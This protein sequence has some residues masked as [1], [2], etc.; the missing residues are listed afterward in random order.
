MS[1]S[2]YVLH[3]Q[4]KGVDTEFTLYT[5]RDEAGGDKALALHMEDAYEADEDDASSDGNTLYAAYET[6]TF[7]NFEDSEEVPYR[8]IRYSDGEGDRAEYC[9]ALEACFV[10]AS[11]RYLIMEA[12]TTLAIDF[13]SSIQTKRLKNRFTDA[14]SP[15]HNAVVVTENIRNGYLSSSKDG[16]FA[17]ADTGTTF[18]TLER[19]THL[20]VLRAQGVGY[21]TT[22]RMMLYLGKEEY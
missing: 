1:V 12:Q 4:V 10:V 15:T 2:E 17:I 5:T 20:L 13:N 9:G 22:S 7:T 8:V 16:N 18:V 21:G 11:E 6:D 14:A 19:G 3:V